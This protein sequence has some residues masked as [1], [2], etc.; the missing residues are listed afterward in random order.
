MISRWTNFLTTDGEKR[1]RNRDGEFETV[2]LDRTELIKAWDEGLKVLID[3]LNS[4]TDEDMKKTVTLYGKKLR[5]LEALHQALTHFSYHVGQIVMLAKHA[6][7]DRWVT[8][9]I[10]RGQSQ[11]FNDA[12]GR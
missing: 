9:G 2:E 11:A 1:W 8:L 5:V 4:L 7:G 6:A 12:G 3:T 10:A